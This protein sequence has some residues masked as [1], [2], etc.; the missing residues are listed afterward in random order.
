MLLDTALAGMIV[1]VFHHLELSKSKPSKKHF[2]LGMLLVIVG[3][4]KYPYL[5]LGPWITVLYLLARRFEMAK[6]LLGGYTVVLMIF[7]IKNII[8]TGAPFGPL[9]SQIS[10]TMASF[11]AVATGSSVYTFDVF[12][13]DF[14]NQWNSVLLLSLI[15]I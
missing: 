7:M 9:Q 12:L 8:H 13:D 11:D 1:S 15:H 4:T 5:Y 2:F 3:M 14:I 10:G 6:L